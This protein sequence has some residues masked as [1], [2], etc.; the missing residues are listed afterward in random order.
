MSLNHAQT[1]A[2]AHNEG[3]CMVL[4]GPGSGKTLTIAKRIE[5][6]IMKH[7]VRPEEILVITFTKYAAGEMRDRF[8]YVMEGRR[9]PVTFGTFH[10]IFYGIL[11]WAYKLDRSNILSEEEKNQLSNLIN[12]NEIHL[13]ELDEL[14]NIENNTYIEEVPKE[15]NKLPELYPVGLALGTY[16]VCENEKGIYLIDQ[17]AAQERINYEKYSY[18]LSHPSQNTTDTLIPIVIE[19]PMNEFLM[20]KKNIQILEELNIKIEE[21]GTSSFRVTSHPTWFSK[22][23]PEDI[24]KRIMEQI[25]KEEK[26]FNLARFRDHLAATMACKAS[27]K[28][29]TRITK[30]DMESIISQLRSC[31]NPLRGRDGHW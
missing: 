21:F 29:N 9:L 6:L 12:F 19:L 28:A 20:I 22:S 15:E 17:H 4:A 30:E 10:G 23:N 1:E 25:V 13:N 5:Y 2:V 3:P 26:N 16:I 31:N 8:Q 11:K 18:L 27:V 7:K 24:L 14:E